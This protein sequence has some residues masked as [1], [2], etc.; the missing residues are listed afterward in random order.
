MVAELFIIKCMKNL[1]IVM[2]LIGPL[3]AFSQKDKIKD[4]IWR[5]EEGLPGGILGSACHRTKCNEP[6]LRS[7]FLNAER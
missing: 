1:I 5:L 4:E 7:K 3:S 6:V 2:L